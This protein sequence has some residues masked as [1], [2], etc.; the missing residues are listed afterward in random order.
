MQLP[1]HQVVAGDHFGNRVLHLQAGVHLQ[2]VVVQLVIYDEL[3]RARAAVAHRQ[4]GGY[5]ILAHG[6]PHRGRDHRRRGLFNYFLPTP[7][8]GAIAFAQVNRIAVRIGKHLNFNMPTVVNQP[9]QHQRAVAKGAG[10]LTARAFDSLLQLGVAAYQSHATSAATGHRFH[11]ERIAELFG[12]QRQHSIAL[13][14]AQVTRS[15]GHARLQH[16]LLGQRLVAHGGDRAGG[17]TDEDHACVHTRLRKGGVLAQEAIAGVNCISARFAG[18][19]E[20]FFN[21]QIRLC[22]G[23]LAD[24]H[25]L[26][27]H[28]HMRGITVRIAVDGHGGVAQLAC[29][30]NDAAGDFATVGDEDFAKHGRPWGIPL[31]EPCGE[32]VRRSALLRVP[33]PLSGL[34]L[35]LRKA[36]HHTG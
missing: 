4:G 33:R 6:F 23:R 30:A 19:I 26:I 22:G 31:G 32:P 35:Y 14:S 8:R 9:L 34:L 16:A 25:R 13:V 20:D 28:R 17:W 11:Q 18:S 3:H 36:L 12:L 21:F 24:M 1:L 5:G 2:K 15:A 10:G 7:L 29:S 27:G